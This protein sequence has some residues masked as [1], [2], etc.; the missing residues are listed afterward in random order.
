M[1]VSGL[2]D[3]HDL[4]G[5][6]ITMLAEAGAIVPEIAAATGRSLKHVTSIWKLTYLASGRAINLR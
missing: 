6:A 2:L 3:E 4:R 5:A 1:I